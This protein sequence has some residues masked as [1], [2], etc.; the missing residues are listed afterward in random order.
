MNGSITPEMGSLAIVGILI[1]FG[2]LALI[3]GVVA[4]LKRLDDRWQE[5]EKR[6][7][8]AAV[9]RTP[10]IDNTTVVLIAAA[11]AVVVGGRFRVR[12]IRRLLSP[13][14]KRTPWS[15]QGRLILQGSHA[16]VRKRD[17]R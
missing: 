11:A 14:Q 10:T 8:E 7:E 16:V 1:V 15:A 4:V 5:H 6:L 17:Q 3:A 12:R 9:D 2:V 13:R